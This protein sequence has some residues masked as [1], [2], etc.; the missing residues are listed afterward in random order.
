MAELA[1]PATM[2][3]RVRAARS[4]GGRTAGRPGL[5]SQELF[6]KESQDSPVLTALLL[7]G[8]DANNCAAVT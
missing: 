1:P 4:R 7:G 8:Q 6:S 5:A 2:K 3:S